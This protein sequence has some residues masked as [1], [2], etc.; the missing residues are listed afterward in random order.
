M[1]P[2][3]RN[4]RESATYQAILDE[5]RAEGEARGRAEGEARGRAEEARRL[6][7][8]LGTARLGAPGA[9]EVAALEAIADP[10]RLERLAQRLFMATSWADLLAA[11]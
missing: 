8:L 5:G 11:P 10:E 2:G 3:V 9:G 7:V 4:M 1:L 6:L